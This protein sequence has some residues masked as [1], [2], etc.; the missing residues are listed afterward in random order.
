MSGRANMAVP[1]P[2]AVDMAIRGGKANAFRLR[3]ALHAL[4][5]HFKSVTFMRE[6]TMAMLDSRVLKQVLGAT[7]RQ[8]EVRYAVD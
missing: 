3:L 1:P 5:V 2:K 6:R 7:A 4:I 8:N